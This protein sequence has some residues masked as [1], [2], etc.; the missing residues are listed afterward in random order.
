MC[1]KNYK[2]IPMFSIIKIKYFLYFKLIKTWACLHYI[3]INN[4]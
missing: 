1:L 2:N 4:V 3:Y